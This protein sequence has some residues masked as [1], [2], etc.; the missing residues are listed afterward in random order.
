MGVTNKAISTKFLNIIIRTNHGQ[1]EMVIQYGGLRC[2]VTCRIVLPFLQQRH[3]HHVF[4]RDNARCHV[5]RVCQD[6][7]NQNHIRVL[8][9]P[10]LSPD[11]S[12]IE[13]L[14]IWLP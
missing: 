8:P 14:Y 2:S 10:A 13:H 12:P 7:L 3:F 11:L 9:W 5:A 4:K 1:T 6:F